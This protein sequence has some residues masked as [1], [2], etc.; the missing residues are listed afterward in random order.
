MQF[1]ALKFQDYYNSKF[2]LEN[3]PIQSRLEMPVRA[4]TQVHSGLKWLWTWMSRLPRPRRAAGRAGLPLTVTRSRQ[5]PPIEND[6]LSAAEWNL[7]VHI[8]LRLDSLHGEIDSEGK[9]CS[10]RVYTGMLPGWLGKSGCPAT[11]TGTV[12]QV[13]SHWALSS[14]GNFQRVN[15]FKIKWPLRLAI[16]AF[17][18]FLELQVEMRSGMP[19]AAPAAAH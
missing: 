3:S 11:G 7:N 16:G 17:L 6:A 2:K 19:R 10:S 15:Q 5:K 4:S 14:T 1:K 13:P 12:F 18:K 9:K 8:W